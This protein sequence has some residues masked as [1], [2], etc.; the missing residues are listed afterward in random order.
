MPLALPNFDWSFNVGNILTLVVMMSGGFGAFYGVKMLIAVL[1]RDME[2]FKESMGRRMAGVEDKI[3]TLGKILIEQAVQSQQILHL[4]QQ[5]EDLKN[6]RGFVFDIGK[7]A[8][9]VDPTPGGRRG[10]R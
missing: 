7:S 10:G 2:N 4:T 9:E 8:Y 5:I 6:G 1:Q 3:D